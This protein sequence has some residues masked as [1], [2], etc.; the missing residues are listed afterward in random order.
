MTSLE[1]SDSSIT[2]AQVEQMALELF[3]AHGVI[4]YSFGFDRAIRRAGQCDYS[5]KR[6]TL[7]KHFVA[8]ANLDQIHQVLLH[9]VAHA[10]VGRSVG[11]G[12]H[13]KQQASLLGYRHEK[14][15]GAVIAAS[16]AKYLGECS[17]G[18]KHFRMRRPSSVL[19]CK[20]CAP[21]F[22]RSHVI[23]WKAI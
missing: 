8:T 19:S 2:D 12:R 13:W 7:S 22:S 23:S 4:N 17:A 15:D 14:L 20:L 11:H 3:Q 16:S 6:I 1:K 21:R 18:H 9:E 10:L 5:K